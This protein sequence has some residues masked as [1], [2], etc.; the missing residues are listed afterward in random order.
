MKK[1]FS[2]IDSII[3]V[4]ISL[5]SIYVAVFSFFGWFESKSIFANLDLISLILALIAMIGIHLVIFNTIQKSHQDQFHKYVNDAIKA[6]NGVIINTFS[7]G[8]EVDRYLAKRVNES[9]AMVCD[10]TWKRK[11]DASHLLPS[12]KAAQKAYISSIKKASMNRKYREIFIFNDKSRF[13]KLETQVKLNKPGY[14]ARYFPIGS[15]IPR[16]QFVVIDG[17]EVI[18][19]SSSY[20]Y[21]CAIQHKEICSIFQKYYDEIWESAIPLIGP[22]EIYHNNINAAKE[23]MEENLIC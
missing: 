8:E 14:Q 7:N 15:N 22:K 4:L 16:I 1:F 9:T 2:Y 3:L 18:F 23:N 10:L 11:L 13:D 19:A 20:P 17:A 5:F 6:V 12:R 21:I